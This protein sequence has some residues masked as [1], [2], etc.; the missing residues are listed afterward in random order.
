MF[1]FQILPHP[2]VFTLYTFFH[3]FKSILQPI[4]PN[5]RKAFEAT[6]PNSKMVNLQKHIFT[7]F[8]HA[9]P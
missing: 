7:A 1:H 9:T 4:L 5:K 8:H 3:Y 2:L 6:I